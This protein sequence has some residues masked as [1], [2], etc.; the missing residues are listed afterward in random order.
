MLEIV[1]RPT[2]RVKGANAAS[3]WR[4]GYK[5]PVV[6]IRNVTDLPANNNLC[7]KG[8]DINVVKVICREDKAR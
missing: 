2:V 5:Y 3:A 1:R 7:I 6:D 4:K 8:L